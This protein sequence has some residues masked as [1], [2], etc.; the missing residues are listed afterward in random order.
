MI[1][2]TEAWNYLSSSFGEQIFFSYTLHC[3]KIM[4][5]YIFDSSIFY[6]HE[7]FLMN[8]H[9]RFRKCKIISKIFHL[10]LKSKASG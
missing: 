10:C 4:Q 8:L 2:C 9:K 5:K 3:W 6:Y 1:V 7:T